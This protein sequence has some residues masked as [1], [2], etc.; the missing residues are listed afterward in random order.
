MGLGCDRHASVCGSRHVGRGWSGSQGHG[1]REARRQGTADLRRVDF[2]SAA[3]AE[4]TGNWNNCIVSWRPDRPDQTKTATAATDTASLCEPPPAS[5]CLPAKV[6]SPSGDCWSKAKT[7]E[8]FELGSFSPRFSI[9]L[10][11]FVH[12]DD[13]ERRHDISNQSV[14][15][16]PISLLP[17]I[18]SVGPS[19]EQKHHNC[20]H[21][22]EMGSRSFHC[23]CW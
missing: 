7:R 14:Y 4:Q 22:Q 1:V 18:E 2:S 9:S 13:A 11:A 23:V 20:C 12:V 8:R 16:A 17:T 6:A 19:T 10:P 21:R 3:G 15:G 5:Q